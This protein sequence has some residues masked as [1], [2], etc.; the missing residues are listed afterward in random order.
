MFD[1]P[2]RVIEPDNSFFLRFGLLVLR[3]YFAGVIQEWQIFYIFGATAF[4]RGSVESLEPAE[5]GFTFFWSS[6]S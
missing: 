1:I 3:L 2:Q 4:G 5:G 6:S